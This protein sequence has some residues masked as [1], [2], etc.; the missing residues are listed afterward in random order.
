[1]PPAVCKFWQQGTCRNGDRCRFLHQSNGVATGNRFAALQTPDTSN[2]R[3]NVG[4][5][6]SQAAS[7][8]TG[9]L[10]FS[11]DKDHIVTDLSS[12]RPQWI[13]SAYGPGR[14]APAQLFGGEQREKSFEEIRLA[15]YA[16]IASGNPQQ[17]VQEADA[18][19]QASEQQIQ[20]A[21]NDVDGAIN[22]IINAEK[23]HPNRI[24]ICKGAQG[25]AAGPSSNPFS[26]NASQP[27]VAKNP[28]G[29]PSQP[30]SISA[31]GA[32][33]GAAGAFGQPSAL[34]AKPNP[35]GAPTQAFGAPSQLGATGGFG[36]P[37]ALG[38]K[39][40]PFG[41]P[42]AGQAPGTSGPSASG[43]A[44]FA[45]TPAPFSQQNQPPST[46]AFGAPSQPTT[47]SAFGAPSQPAPAG[48]FGAPSQTAQSSAFGA[49]SQPAQSSAFG[50]PSQLGQ[51]RPFGTSTSQTQPNPF[52]SN[53]SQPFGGPP[54]S[55]PDFG[56][57]SQ[58]ATQ[59]PFGGATGQQQNPFGAP[60]SASAATPNPFGP[61]QP[62]PT[63]PPNPFGNAGA[64]PSGATPFGTPAQPVVN[65]H[66]G[67]GSQHPPL[68]NY[69]SKDG[70]GRLTMFKGKRVIYR[71]GE[72]GVQNRD[73]TWAKI[74]F[75]DGPPPYYK[76]TELED[77]AYDENTKAAYMHM[78][79]TG[80]FQ[81]GAMPLVPPKREWCLWDF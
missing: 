15:H 67:K 53:T 78:M 29:A 32:P 51:S 30:A 27:T 9:Q 7:S 58:P 54:P 71:D 6:Q 72:P 75:P 17:A 3:R 62:T 26:T 5:H 1:M 48:V 39:P 21:L 50:A 34:G 2:P 18:L 38:Q 47:S 73:G 74:W 22:F 77:E 57:L 52:A 60:S 23:E 41:A 45:G 76:D 20:T 64:G 42:S 37:S 49:P 14:N 63:A 12:E 16:G 68:S 8:S 36:Q 80:M 25:A 46:N 61:P 13:L 19:Y 79:Q 11:L 24:D 59:T 35:F 65:G 44:A 69:A 4:Y 28:F 55:K 43:F 31:F 56:A 66:A 33:S 81:N 10:P 70:S 40:N